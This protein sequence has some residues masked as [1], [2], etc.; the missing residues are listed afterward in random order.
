MSE[1]LELDVC[2][3]LALEKRKTLIVSPAAESEQDLL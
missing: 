2:L 3:D 1:I